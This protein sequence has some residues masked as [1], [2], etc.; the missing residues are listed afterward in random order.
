[1]ELGQM[2]TL[3]QVAKKTLEQ[4][5]I[6]ATFKTKTK[7]VMGQRVPDQSSSITSPIWST[8]YHTNMR[9]T[10]DNTYLL[11]FHKQNI[12]QRCSFAQQMIQAK[13]PS[14]LFNIYA[15]K[16]LTK[17]WHLCYFFFLYIYTF[18]HVMGCNKQCQLVYNS[19]QNVSI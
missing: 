17:H 14:W 10:L 12:T 16:I 18:T 4:T 2:K 11:W 1:M 15:C 9:Q 5:S 19:T 3:L 7:Q 6:I 8:D 13:L